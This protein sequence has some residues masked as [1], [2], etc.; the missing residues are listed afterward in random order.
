MK[1]IL[2]V[3][4]DQGILDAFTAILE[5]A[6]FEVITQSDPDKLPKAITTVKPDLIILDVL[7]SGGDGRE[8][9]KSLKSKKETKNIPVI[10]ISA[11]PSAGESIK[12]SGAD[13]FL[14]KPFEMEELLNKVNKFTGAN[15]N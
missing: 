2:V 13:D 8:I 6:D 4:D 5:S 11:H 10:I 14:E 12:T 15:T 3:D 1:K 9:C 7:L